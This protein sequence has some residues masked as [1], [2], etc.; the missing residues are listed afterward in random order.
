MKCVSCGKELEDGAKFCMFCGAKQPVAVEPVQEPPAPAVADT[1]PQPVAAEAPIPAPEP[2]HVAEPEPA[3]V[4]EPQPM[5]APEPMPV[6]VP[7]PTT[8]PAPAPAPTPEPA[9]APA[10]Q[11]AKKSNARTIIIAILGVLVIAG[12]AVGMMLANAAKQRA[13][14]YDNAVSLYE[15]G[16][17]EE[18]AQAFEELGDYE[19]SAALHEKA[20]L[21]IAAQNAEAAAGEDP[22]AWNAAAE[23]YDRVDAAGSV[24]AASRCRNK[25]SYYTALGL[26]DEGKWDE[27]N[28]ILN[29]LPPSEFDDLVELLTSCSVHKTYEEAEG[30]LAEGSFYDAYKLFNSISGYSY[31][32]LPD[33]YEKAQSCIQS[34][35]SE[36]AVYRNSSYSS[37]DC[38]LTI[39]N[40]GYTNAYY[41]L[42]QGDTLVMTI[43]IKGGSSAYV[44]LPAGVYRMNKAYGEM[45]F[46]TDDMFGDDGA[47]YRCS[48]GGSETFELEAGW[49]YTISAGEGGT[50]ISNSSTDRESF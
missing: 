18:A 6:A 45:W 12:I 50:G 48:F 19:D 21:W 42:Y 49:S 8:E 41:K 4:A 10:P 9:P 33:L 23:A 46:G 47:Y 1:I 43:F 29:S 40:S 31:D 14:A 7:Q 17:Y 13:E 28:E 30:L 26:M 20:L 38:D 16:R 22:E 2:A 36:G 44:E 11:P 25:A 39:D 27:A 35:P 3:S 24:A 5:P 32:D 37:S 34:F 15:A